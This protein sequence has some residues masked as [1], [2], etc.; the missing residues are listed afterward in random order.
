M[1]LLSA[2]LTAAL[3]WP[4]FAQAADLQLEVQGLDTSRL[5][6]GSLMVAVFTEPSGWLRQ[7]KIGQRFSLEGAVDGKLTVTLRN[8]PDG[9]VAVTVFQDANGNGRLD[10]NA[11]GMPVEP[12]GF[13]N[14]AAGQFGPPKFEQA[15]FTPVAGQA[16]RLR[17]N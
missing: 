4:S 15:V 11:M 9:P 6:G 8:L 7:P 14:D 17:L 16:V 3:V 13:S 12:Y 2:A 5:Q 1:K 10:M